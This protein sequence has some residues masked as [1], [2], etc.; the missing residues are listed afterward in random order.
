MKNI[1]NL[2]WYVFLIIFALTMLFAGAIRK[3]PE[4]LINFSLGFG[5]LLWLAIKFQRYKRDKKG[6]EI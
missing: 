6:S 5:I 2:V 1:L 4:S 3:I